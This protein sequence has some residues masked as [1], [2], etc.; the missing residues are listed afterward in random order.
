MLPA[1]VG[2]VCARSAPSWLW[3]CVQAGL[4]DREAAACCF[5]LGLSEEDFMCLNNAKILY[6]EIESCN[7]KQIRQ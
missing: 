2:R 1:K 6:L 5:R 4:E 3:D 7:T